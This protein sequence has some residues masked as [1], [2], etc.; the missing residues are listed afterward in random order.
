MAKVNFFLKE[1]NSLDSLIYLCIDSKGKRIKISTGEKINP[2]FWDQD[3]HRAKSTSKFP[4][5]PELNSFLNSLEVETEKFILTAK[6]GIVLP[7]TLKQ[8]IKKYLGKGEIKPNSFYSVFKEFKEISAIARHGRTIQKYSTLETHLTDFQKVKRVNITFENIDVKLYDKLHSYYLNDLK[9][10]NNTFGKYISTLKTFL[11]WAT[12]RGYNTKL[13]YRKYKVVNNE[14][15]II[16]LSSE[17]LKK[18]YDLDLS[19]NSRLERVRDTFCL[20]CYTGLRFS[21][22]E[23]LKKENINKDHLL[24]KTYK[25]KETLFI[26]LREEAKKII[27]KYEKESR[28]LPVISNQKMNEYLKEVGKLAKINSKVTITKYR[29]AEPI[30]F[31][32]PKYKFLS[33]HTARRTFVT[34]SLENGARPEVVMEI[35]GHKNYKTFKKYIKL[36]SKVVESEMRKVWETKE[37]ITPILKV[38]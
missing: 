13:D 27:K 22:L 38:I 5:Y 14:A 12:E 37:V 26:P 19:K 29:G 21:D 31:K 20:G 30:E 24:L 6:A 2:R 4:Q 3:N 7:E 23:N 1:P 32:K 16:Y 33:T 10:L 15:D 28:F 9:L 11:N 34:L 25:T 17:E 8:H 36:T 18:L 35:T